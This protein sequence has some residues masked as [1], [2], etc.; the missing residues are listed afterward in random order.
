MIDKPTGSPGLSRRALLLGGGAL[1]LSACAPASPAATPAP[2]GGSPTLDGLTGT[3]SSTTAT[4]TPPPAPTRSEIWTEFNGRK[5]KHFAL[6][7]PGVVTQTRQDIAL[8]FDACGGGKLG[9]GY[10]ARVL[11]E[12]EK[13]EVPATL[14]V[15][16]RWIDAN[17]DLAL[18]LAGHPL[19]ELANHGWEHR[20][21]TIAGQRAYGIKGT[22]GAGQVYD[23]IIHGRDRLAEITGQQSPW[24][25]PGTAWADDVAIEI[26]DRLGVTLVG[27]TVNADAGA[28]A[29][30]KAIT[31]KLDKLRKRDIVLAHF[32]RPEG[33]TAEALAATLPRLQDTG[34]TFATLTDALA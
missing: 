20:P 25:R 34:R 24:F 9:D 32:N 2:T 18:D 28:G 22:V 26:A 30:R 12:L 11:A 6:E 27:F 8:T 5:P 13:H 23:E 29:S 19:V 7:L 21:L 10:D 16:A 31:K 33:H 1:L 15:N 14:F 3:T 4:S 17:P